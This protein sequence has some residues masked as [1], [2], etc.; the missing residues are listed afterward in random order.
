MVAFASLISPALSGER[1]WTQEV[2]R[3]VRATVVLVGAAMSLIACNATQESQDCG[4]DVSSD[5][6]R[7]HMFTIAIAS[8][9]GSAKDTVQDTANAAAGLRGSSLGNPNVFMRGV[10]L[11]RSQLYRDS[12]L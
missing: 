3:S 5:A 7:W 2:A 10:I 1:R 11:D 12:E 8:P 4:F 6:P 9:V